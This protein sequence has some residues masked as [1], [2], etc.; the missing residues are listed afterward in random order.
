[1]TGRIVVGVDG[2]EQSANALEWGVARA[3]LGGHPLE[4]VNTYTVLPAM[5]FYGYQGVAGQQ[6]V[7]WLAEG[8][9]QLLE[10]A[11]GRVRELAPDLPCT[12]T[13]R[14]G[15]A[16]PV[17]AAVAEGASTLVLGRRGLGAA[18]SAVFGSV[19]NR[20][21]VEAPCP[22]VVVGDGPLPTGGPVVVGVDG[23]AYGT[24]A[25]RF[26]VAEAAARG[27]A[28]RAVVAYD[29]PH[30]AFRADPELTARMRAEVEAEAA[31][32]IDLAEVPSGVAVETVTVEGPAAPAI[33]ANAED[34][35][36]VVVGSHG[37]GFVRRILLGSVSRQ[38]LSEAERPVA[39]V[40]LPER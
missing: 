11:A 15:H 16:A 9:Q 17:L 32:S 36:L 37:K 6:P 35:Q 5:S 8:S 3:L 28:V 22:L 26:A 12:L 21:A 27:T 24:Q 10:A 29:L 7:E 33:L 25:L 23:S 30:P 34:A 40:D 20:L 2:S 19:S 39:V 13:S 1:M 4:V 31:A 38:V 14:L 18:A